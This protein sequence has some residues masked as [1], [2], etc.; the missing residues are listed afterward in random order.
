MRAPRRTVVWLVL[1][2][3]LAAKRRVISL[4]DLRLREMTHGTKHLRFHCTSCG[5]CCREFR[6]P[7]TDS[8]VRRMAAAMP[9]IEPADWLDWL[10]PRDVDMS[11]EPETFVELPSG[12]RLLV[13]RQIDGACS[14]LAEQ[15]CSV[16]EARPRSCRLFPWDVSLGR[17]GGVRR[18]ALLP[19]AQVC[20][21]TQDG[22]T[23]PEHL[24]DQKRWER[25]ELAAYVRRVAA[26]N[27]LQARRKRLG[28]PLLD[29]ARFLAS[30]LRGEHAPNVTSATTASASDV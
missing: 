4:A 5:N 22:N 10:G 27:R 6:V 28:K 8:D 12:R 29:A 7:V 13:L 23:R 30:L 25:A 19:G 3:R 26:W 11:G 1:I 14:R 15:R 9:S 24:A 21:S 17:R 20:E 18:L 16:Y 2:L